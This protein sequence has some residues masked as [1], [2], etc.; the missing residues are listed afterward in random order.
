M[1]IGLVILREGGCVKIRWIC[2]G[3]VMRV[4]MRRF[5]RD[6]VCCMKWFLKEVF[7]IG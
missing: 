7:R 2:G 5:V 4:L 3:L 6:L 1:I